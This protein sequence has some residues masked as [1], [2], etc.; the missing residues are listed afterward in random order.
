[1]TEPTLMID[2]SR[3]QEF[4][5]DIKRLKETLNV[6]AVAIRYGQDDWADPKVRQHYDN[7]RGEADA[8]IAYFFPDPLHPDVSAEFF[9]EQLDEMPADAWMNDA[10]RW[11]LLWKEWDEWV[12][13]KTRKQANVRRIPPLQLSAGYERFENLVAADSDLPGLTYTGGYM[14]D[15]YMPSAVEWLKRKNL[16]M[17]HWKSNKPNVPAAISTEDFKALIPTGEPY[18]GELMRG[19]S[20][21]AWQ[22]ITNRQPPGCYTKTDFSLLQVSWEEFRQVLRLGEPTWD[23]MTAAERDVIVRKD[24]TARGILDAE[25]RVV[26]A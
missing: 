7:L 26:G 19:W 4:T 3:Y 21:I 2:I 23:R 9:C 18:K 1:M 25:G 24:L 14:V 13:K 8:V 5:P 12:M 20:T 22:F 10:E 11:W 17:A 6:R 15:Q 16:V